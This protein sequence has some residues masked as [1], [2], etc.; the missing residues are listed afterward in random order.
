M[1]EPRPAAD[2][3]S[4]S[5]ADEDRTREVLSV[6]LPGLWDVVN[7]LTRLKP[8]HHERDRVSIFGAGPGRAPATSPTSRRGA[9]PRRSLIW[10]ATSSLAVGPV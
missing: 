8:T 4:V 3:R 7:P 9:W 1:T 2:A 10:A 5:L 6:A